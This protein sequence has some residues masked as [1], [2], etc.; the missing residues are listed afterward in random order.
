[1]A[2][3]VT[4]DEPSYVAKL[5]LAQHARTVTQI[6]ETGTIIV[7]SF[8]I[9]PPPSSRTIAPV[10]VANARPAGMSATLVQRLHPSRLISNEYPNLL[11]GIGAS[12]GGLPPLLEIIDHLSAS[13]QGAIFVAMHRP[14]GLALCPHVIPA[15]A[16]IQT[17]AK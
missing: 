14:L 9:L 17:R 15:Q 11:I 8:R 13:Y 3:F 6:H 12:A 10:H 1:M 2:A 5:A 4:K 7:R 16:G